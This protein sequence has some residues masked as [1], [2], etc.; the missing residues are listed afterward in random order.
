MSTI[1]LKHSG[2][3]SVSLNPPTSAPTSSEVAFKLPNADGSSGQYMKTDGSGNLAFATIAAGIDGITEFDVWTLGGTMGN[4][5]VTNVARTNITGGAAQIGT[6]MTQSSGV[7]TFPSTGKWLVI[8]KAFF[9]IHNTDNAFLDTEVTADNANSWTNHGVCGCGA[10]GTG[11]FAVD[12]S[13]SFSWIDVTDT[14]NV[15]VKFSVSSVAGSTY[16]DGHATNKQY[17]QFLFI[18]IGDT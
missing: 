16:L 13:T 10:N 9:N 4:G 6:G 5:D 3:N 14:S 15:K 11:G 1:K 7:F 2:G 17:T 8:A 12:S 18:R